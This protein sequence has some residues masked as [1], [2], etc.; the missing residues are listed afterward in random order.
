MF[1]FTESFRELT[2]ACKDVLD[3]L[4]GL[5]H[6]G[7]LE[8]ID[9]RFGPPSEGKLPFYIIRNGHSTHLGDLCDSYPPFEKMRGWMERAM[10]KSAIGNYCTEIL[11]LDCSQCSMMIILA[12]SDWSMFNCGKGKKI[13][14]PVSVL[15]ILQT[16]SDT[17]KVLCFCRTDRTI[18]NLYRALSDVLKRYCSLFDNPQH[19]FLYNRP[20]AGTKFWKTSELLKE[21]VISNELDDFKKFSGIDDIRQKRVI[22]LQKRGL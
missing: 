20:W 3:Y 5:P 14:R 19:W 9:F 16:G 2:I 21:Q 4:T 8:D 13:L 22:P 6:S 17:P 7:E 18:S 12:Q 10:T 15:A 11:N 1:G